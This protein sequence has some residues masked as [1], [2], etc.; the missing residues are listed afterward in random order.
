MSVA[1]PWLQPSSGIRQAA[2][3]R[4]SV[5]PLCPG[6]G[7]LLPHVAMHARAACCVCTSKHP[8]VDSSINVWSAALA[9]LPCVVAVRLSELGCD[10]PVSDVYT[11]VSMLSQCRSVLADCPGIAGCN[12]INMVAACL[13][14]IVDALC[15]SMLTLHASLT[16]G[17]SPAVLTSCN[18]RALSKQGC[19][20]RLNRM[21]TQWI[22]LFRL[23]IIGS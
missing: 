17:H 14:K 20:T 1:K 7:Q 3:S 15:V 13:C 23:L 22:D 18:S 2:L 4:W 16:P 12:R 6:A 5:S 21:T 10:A 8:C 9:E 19:Y 11:T